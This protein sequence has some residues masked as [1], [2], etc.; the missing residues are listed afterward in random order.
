MTS[1]PCPWLDETSSILLWPQLKEPL[2]RS[3]FD[4]LLGR[5]KP[6]KPV[7][8]IFLDGRVLSHTSGRVDLEQPFNVLLSVWPYDDHPGVIEL[9]VTLRAVSPIHSTQQPNTSLQLRTVW[10][11][12]KHTVQQRKQ[13]Y[14]HFCRP[15]SF[16]ELW[17]ALTV[18]S[19]IHNQPRPSGL[20]LENLDVQDLRELESYNELISCISCGSLDVTVTGQEVFQCN[21]CGYLGGEGLE[22]KREQERLAAIEAMTTDERFAKCKDLLTDAR[23]MMSACAGS[24][25]DVMRRQVSGEPG[26]YEEYDPW[27]SDIGHTAFSELQHIKRA[28]SHAAELMP[29]L[30]SRFHAAS[31]NVHHAALAD[32]HEI[33]SNRK[34]IREG[35]ETGLA[36]IDALLDEWSTLSP[37]SGKP[38]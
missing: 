32:A 18:F 20:V 33:K 1:S 8:E 14:Q 26:R 23:H 21:D 10:P 13:G 36:W 4:R 34:D 6:P 5:K 37:E 12:D 7:D 27:T 24:L 3:W 31:V 38:R 15:E 11:D 22:R 19:D 30:A 16:V 17:K 9:N 28:L 2:P 35:L 25:V 29:Q